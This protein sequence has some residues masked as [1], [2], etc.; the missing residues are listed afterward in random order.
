MMLGI[1]AVILLLGVFIPPIFIAVMFV[2]PVPFVFYASRYGWKPSMIMLAIAIILTSM[3]ATFLSIPLAVM[4]G[5][6]G[7]M[8]GHGIF[9]ERS[10]Y[11]T[12]ARGTLGF[13]AGLLF[14]FVFSQ[15]LLS[16]NFAEE[17]E[18]IMNDSMEM[19]TSFMESLGVGDQAEQTEELFRTQL[20]LML[21][22]LP[23]IIALTAI[24]M[25][26]LS[27]WISYKVLNRVAKK[28][29]RFPAFRNLS[30]PSS[31]IW[32]YFFTWLFS[33]MNLDPQSATY[34]G[35]QN[36]F[37]L[38]AILLTVQG[39]S[40]IFHYAHSKKVW[41]GI[42]VFIVVTSLL[43]PGM[44]YFVRILGIIDIGFKLR[45]RLNSKK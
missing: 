12:W 26:F 28:E 14:V 31:I 29:L 45:D 27:Q 42:P 2:L 41:K 15:V 20:D 18:S 37:V 13:I 43:L 6:G 11:E 17:L 16:V 22:L 38:T 24:V 35:V 4:M 34:M 40:F 3:F 19:S 33:L 1:Y 39:F 36:V 23:A 32:V 5:L 44:L 9:K 25:A 21:N 7:I 10:A 8:I 30:F